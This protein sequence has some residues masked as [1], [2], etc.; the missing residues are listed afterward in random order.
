MKPEAEIVV[1]QLYTKEHQGLLGKHQKLA[2]ARKDSFLQTSEGARPPNTL[3]S[4]F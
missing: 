1:M 2:E 4:D 3:L